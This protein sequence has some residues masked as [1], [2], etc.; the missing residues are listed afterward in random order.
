MAHEDSGKLRASPPSIP[1]GENISGDEQV[2]IPEAERT[3]TCSYLEESDSRAG[4]STAAAYGI[5]CEL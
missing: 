5:T 3:P 1:Y 4:L 2:L